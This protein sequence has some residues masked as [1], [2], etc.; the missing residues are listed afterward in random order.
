MSTK[1][2][3]VDSPHFGDRAIV[4]PE[5]RSEE[6]GVLG[7]TNYD[8]VAWPAVDRDAVGNY[9]VARCHVGFQ[10]GKAAVPARAHSAPQ[11][12][13][14]SVSPHRVLLFLGQLRKLHFDCPGNLGAMVAREGLRSR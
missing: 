14:V 6:L 5:D 2:L 4:V 10:A 9:L 1:L 3:Q 8:G 11:R 13:A 12:R 7:V